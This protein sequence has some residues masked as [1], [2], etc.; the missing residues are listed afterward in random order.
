MKRFTKEIIL[1]LI[2]L[3]PYVYL[4]IVWDQ[5]PD[6]VPTHFNVHG[7]ADD[8]SDR[9]V[10]WIIPGALGL[11]IYFLMLFIPKLDPRNQLQQMG[12]KYDTL[13]VLLNL[14]ISL[15]SAYL[16]Y[17]AQST[18]MQ[19][20][21][22]LFALLGAFFALLGNYFQTVRPNYFIG[23]RTPWTLDN[24]TIW[25]QT[26]V[27]AGRIWSVSGLILVILAFVL[28][29]ESYFIIFIIIMSVMVIVPV[30]YSYV[31]FVKIRKS[32]QIN[33]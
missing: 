3:L 19:S 18:I 1:W 25:K 31:S 24:E 17:A 20:P 7:Q 4:A 30:G 16:I 21:Q 5:L 14:F 32:Q 6:R 10:L 33:H 11:G 28:S 8:W 29:P 9:S 15:L 22:W 26:H 23:I 13:R 2:I 12:V 27:L